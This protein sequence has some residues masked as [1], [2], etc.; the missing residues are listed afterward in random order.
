[1]LTDT[2]IGTAT[3]EELVDLRTRIFEEIRRRDR[4]DANLADEE[5]SSPPQRRS[6]R[7]VVERKGGN[8]R[9]LHLKRVKCGK[10]EHRLFLM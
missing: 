10:C 4:E 3:R 1:V 2:Q 8:G 7:D 6:G 9:W 5:T